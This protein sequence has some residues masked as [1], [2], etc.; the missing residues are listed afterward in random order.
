MA[1]GSEAGGCLGAAAARGMAMRS[2][3]PQPATATDPAKAARNVRRV[4]AGR[5]PAFDDNTTWNMYRPSRRARTTMVSLE[6][7]LFGGERRGSQAC[8]S[9]LLA[10]S[11]PEATLK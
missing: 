3:I 8:S 9:G 11:W 1:A 4:I 5:F 10:F 7:G 2:G 6:A